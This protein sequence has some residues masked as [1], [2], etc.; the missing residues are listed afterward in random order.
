MIKMENSFARRDGF[1]FDASST[2]ISL[3]NLRKLDCYANRKPIPHQ[4]PDRLS[5]ENA[6]EGNSVKRHGR[7]TNLHCNRVQWT[8]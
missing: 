3:R 8:G 4:V 7:S 6:I 2:Q 1:W 5:L